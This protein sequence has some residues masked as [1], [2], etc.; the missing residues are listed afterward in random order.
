MVPEGEPC[1]MKGDEKAAR[2]YA[3]L[4]HPVRIAILRQ[5]ILEE[6]CCCKDIVGRV[7]L[8]Q[9]TVSQHLKVLVQAGL[10]DYRPQ[11]RTS[12]YSVN[13]LQLH[14]ICDHLTAL[15][16]DCCSAV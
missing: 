8:A 9:S 6:A 15:T 2:V 1:A 14:A 16:T 13:R 7:D 3:A 4:G 12:R 11:Q 10:V 5:L